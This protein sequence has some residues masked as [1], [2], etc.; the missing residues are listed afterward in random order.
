MELNETVGTNYSCY[1]ERNRGWKT[2]F[3]YSKIYSAL[4]RL[5]INYILVDSLVISY[6]L[7]VGLTEVKHGL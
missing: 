6:K 7:Q 3:E 5:I 2:S 1:E 4:N